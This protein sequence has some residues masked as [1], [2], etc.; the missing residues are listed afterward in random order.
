MSDLRAFLEELTAA[1]SA[2]LLWT[3]HCAK[4]AD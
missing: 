3:K 4:M 1:P 2:E